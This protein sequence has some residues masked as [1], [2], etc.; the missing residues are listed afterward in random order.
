V[1]QPSTEMTIFTITNPHLIQ[2]L[3]LL[4][5]TKQ[6]SGEH[7]RLGTFHCHEALAK[8]GIG[9]GPW[10]IIPSIIDPLLCSEHPG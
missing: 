3:P 8:P 1:P 6:E 2:T 10:R 5:E 7:D 9:Q 4:E